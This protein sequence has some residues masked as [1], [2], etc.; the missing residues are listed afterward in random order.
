MAIL[1][2][3]LPKGHLWNKVKELMDQAG[4]GLNVRSERSYLVNSNDPELELRIYR[5]QNI[6]PLVEEGKYDLGI[7]GHDWV[8]ESE[9]NVEEILDL[10]LGRVNVVVAVPQKYK[11]K[12]SKKNENR[13]FRQLVERVKLEGKERIIAA[14][15]YE[16]ITK[17]LCEEKLG[18]FPYRFIRS[19]G[20]TETFIEVADL[21]VDC[22]ETG[23]TLRENGWEIIY[24]IFQSTAH[25]IANKGSLKDTWKK[26]KIEDFIMLLKGAKD[27]T[28]LKLLKMN[29][30][31]S[32][33]E[34]V[35]AVL[36]AMKSPTISSLY[37]DGEPGYAVE[38]AVREDQ[39]VK[40]IPILKKKGATDILEID[41]K[42]V[43]K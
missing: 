32:A 8:M 22:T 37:G 1:K 33:I 7:T 29:V 36:P 42:K 27:A 41:I 12:P 10:E 38:V 16:N 19:F 24:T 35:T 23:I 30:P 39:V 2:V 31:E 17:T 15:E 34:K 13:V 26:G 40:L 43:V 5:A 21:I 9:V 20:A 6:G 4:Y 3:A 18:G 25:V 11:I 14:S 28:G